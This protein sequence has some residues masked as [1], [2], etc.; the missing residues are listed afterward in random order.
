MLSQ[1]ELTMI[2]TNAFTVKMLLTY[3]NGLI[4]L[5]GNSAWIAVIISTA[6]AAAVFWITTLLYVPNKNIIGI[7]ETLGGSGLRIAT[8]VA[9]FVIMALGFFGVWR[10]FV[11]IIRL[12]LLQG[13]YIEFIALLFGITLL[14]GAMC[15]IKAIGRVHGIFIPV[16]AISF[17]LF[18]ILA[19]P[20]FK[21]LNIFPIFGKGV[22]NTFLYGFNGLSIFGD[23]LMLNILI[24]YSGTLNNYKKSGA[25]SIWIGGACAFLIMICYNL[26][27][28]YPASAD[29]IVPVYQVERLMRFSSFFSR[30]EAVFQLIWSLA[31]MLYGSAYS[32]TMALVWQSTFKLK[33]IK[34]VIYVTV[35][36]MGA[37]ALVPED[38]EL[39]ILMERIINKYLFI[40]VL[41]LP[42]I[43]GAVSRIKAKKA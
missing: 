21:T 43:F 32:Y 19:V 13:T 36:A 42:L 20:E 23:L 16:A 26:I 37:A 1:K 34:P 27:Y 8:G 2:I 7:A 29:F 4:D 5:C 14:L 6:A 17:V 38:F 33:D 9:V 31:I 10:S 40:P 18:V 12:V 39:M 35:A 41:L 15:G 25:K 3:P 28:T 24:P 11:E 22:K 30:F